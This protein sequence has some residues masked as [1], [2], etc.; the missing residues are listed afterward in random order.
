VVQRSNRQ[1]N[2]NPAKVSSKR[3]K[4]IFPKGLWVIF[5]G[6]GSGWSWLFGF[7]QAKKEKALE[8]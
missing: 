6:A 1:Q 3:A 2:S 4:G 5:L 7:W 8:G